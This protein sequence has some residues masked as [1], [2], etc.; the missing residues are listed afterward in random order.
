M[1]RLGEDRPDAGVLDHVAAA[2]GRVLGV[3]RHVGQA[4]LDDGQQRHDHVERAVHI[5]PHEVGAGIFLTEHAGDPVGAPVQLLVGEGLILVFHSDRRRRPGRLRLDE[6]DDRPVR[7]IGSG[8]VPLLEYQPLLALRE[9][10]DTV[11]L[12]V[13]VLAE[14]AQQVAVVVE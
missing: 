12:G 3:D 5:D 10:R 2:L 7:V 11:H 8:G 9:D 1:M 13:Y 4:G 6:I 14:L